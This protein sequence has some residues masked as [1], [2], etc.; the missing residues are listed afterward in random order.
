V[1]VDVL[2][3]TQNEAEMVIRLLQGRWTQ[4]GRF[5]GGTAFELQFGTTE[6]AQKYKAAFENA[7]R[8]QPLS[9]EVPP[10]SLE[11]ACADR[12]EE[13]EDED[14]AL[15]K[16]LADVGIN[17]VSQEV[18][19]RIDGHAARHGLDDKLVR[20]LYGASDAIASSVIAVEIPGNVRNSSAYVSRVLRDKARE[21]QYDEAGYGAGEQYDEAGYGAGEQHDEAGYGAGEQ[22]EEAG[23]GA[24]KQHE[25]ANDDAGEQYEEAGVSAG[26][27]THWRLEATWR[28]TPL[29]DDDEEEWAEEEEEGQWDEWT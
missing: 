18:R 19:A 21:E 5:G 13:E 8:I 26:R 14:G 23:Y 20:K 3:Q 15:S 25:G 12:D 16:P 2:G 17:E 4:N 24:G 11:L 22:Y 10:A 9:V 29:P 27:T 1:R 7:K 6:L 28:V